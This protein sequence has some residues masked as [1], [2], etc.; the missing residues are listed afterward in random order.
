MY[1]L[2]TSAVLFIVLTPGVLVTIP[3]GASPVVAAIVHAIVF[4]VVQ[5]YL[6]TI[7][8]WW[9]IWIIGGLVVGM[10][11]FTRTSPAP[12]LY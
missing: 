3:P 4:Y 5:A 7:V 1:S 9:A 8:P 10:K 2:L 11:L 12:P 6:S